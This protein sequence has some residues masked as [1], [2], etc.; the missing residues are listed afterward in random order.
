MSLFAFYMIFFGIS[1][2]IGVPLLSSFQVTQIKGSTYADWVSGLGASLGPAAG[3]MI[4]VSTIAFFMMKPLNK[5]LQDSKTRELSFD[6]KI[7]AKKCLNRLNFVT[8]ISLFAGYPLGNGTT[9]IIK[10]LTGKVN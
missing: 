1:T 8:V 7:R 2:V 6:E 4:I 3:I 5:A 9:I 10:T